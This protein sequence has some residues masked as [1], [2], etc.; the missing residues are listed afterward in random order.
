MRSG[1]AF[2]FVFA[3]RN[4][5]TPF[6]KIGVSGISGAAVGGMVGNP[7]A[8]AA[9]A[10]FNQAAGIR[11]DVP[12]FRL[13]SRR[14]AFDLARRLNRDLRNVPRMSK[15]LGSILT[16]AENAAFGLA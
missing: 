1:A 11:N 6:E 16:R 2:H 13:I 9:G 12:E 5:V 15:L 7:L 8:G 10:A 14:G 4:I 3:S